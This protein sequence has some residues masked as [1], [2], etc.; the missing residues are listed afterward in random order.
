MP[1]LKSTQK[2]DLLPTPNYS[3]MIKYYL[4]ILLFFSISVIFGQLPQKPWNPI[5]FNSKE[6]LWQ[7][8]LYDEYAKSDST[9]GYNKLE[10]WFDDVIIFDNS[11]ITYS[12]IKSKDIEGGFIQRTDLSSGKTIWKNRFD[13]ILDGKQKG[14]KSMF[15]NKN[16]NV[17]IIGNVSLDSFSNNRFLPFGVRDDRTVFFRKIYDVNSGKLIYNFEAN[18]NTGL[19]MSYSIAGG[20]RHTRMY[21]NEIEENI[22][23]IRNPLING[24]QALQMVE[25]DTFGVPLSYSDTLKI[26]GLVRAILKDDS[27]LIALT[28]DSQRIVLQYFDEKFK[29]KKI[30]KLPKEISSD[31]YGI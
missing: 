21:K 17:E 18:E 9:D 16:N 27:T 30:K 20:S 11:I 8:T 31:N 2:R 15:L 4:F 10:F 3:Y 26:T 6:P 7:N 13:Y 1:I 28:S 29:T 25:I 22:K 24:S 12:Y 5:E 14:P 23:I 19:M